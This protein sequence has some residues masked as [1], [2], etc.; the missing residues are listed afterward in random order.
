[1][2]YE[3]AYNCQLIVEDK[4]EIIVGNHISDSPVDVT[5]TEPTMEKFKQEQKV[6]LKRVE[7]FQDNG[8]SSSIAAEYYEKE[9]AIAY[10]PDPVTTKELHGK[11][12][13]TPKF[14]NDNFKLDFKKNQAICPAGHRMDFARKIIK[15]KHTFLNYQLFT[16]NHHVKFTRRFS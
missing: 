10:I 11:A 12:K 8:F 2:H 7:V 4:G 5:E 13:D 16:I 9:G 14:H 15:K 3:Q 6:S 1:M